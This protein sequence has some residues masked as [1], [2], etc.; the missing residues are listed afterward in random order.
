MVLLS[1]ENVSKSFGIK[2]LFTG[3]TVGL[4]DGEKIGVIGA[5]GS[6]KST[7]LKVIAGEEVPDTGRVV[8]STG[9]LVA[10][11]PQNPPFDPEA[12][13]LA[14]VFHGGNDALQSKLDLIQSYELACHEL[15]IDGGTDEK[16]LGRVS[17]L[18]HELEVTGA[19]Q[20]ESDA[21]AMLTEL[22]VV[23]LTAKM[24]TLSGGQRKR[25]ALAHSLLI[26]PDLLILDEPTNHLDA[27]TVEWL[28]RALMNFRGALLLVTHDRYFLDRV[29]NRM[30]E[31]ERGKVQSFTGNYASY[32]EQ[33]QTQ[34]ERQAVEAQKLKQMARR[35][36]EWLRRGPKARTTKAKARIDRAEGVIQQAKQAATDL[37]SRRS[38]ELTFESSRLGGKI[39]TLHNLTHG[40]GDRI[41]IRNFSYQFKRGDRIGVIGP[42]GVGK[43]TFMEILAGQLKPQS[44]EVEIGQ[45]V[46]ISYYRQENRDFDETQRLI[47]HIREVAERIQL[48]DGET[49]T[50]G[51]M[52]ERFLFPP[53][54][55]YQ[56]IG[57][58]S[59]GERR[60]LSLLRQLMSAPNMLL[61]DEVTNDLDLP[62][63]VALEDYLESFPGCLVI[64]SHDRYFI[65]R[66]VETIFRLEAGGV[67]REYPGNYS[68]FREIMERERKE[69]AATLRP[70]RGAT[71]PAPVALVAPVP[72]AE[73]AVADL[74]SD[75][76]KKL[77]FKEKRELEELEVKIATMEQRKLEVEGQLAAQGSDH[78]A[79]TQLYAELQELV[80]VLERNLTRWTELAERES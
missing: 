54:M 60:R 69:A 78:L 6:G 16:L 20:I 64:V 57:T 66:T 39:V 44:G 19:W 49:I 18:A 38:L 62:T 73:V 76:R 61:L 27:E 63:L 29:T 46:A 17:D 70:A 22:G 80:G 53:A 77:S 34:G 59:G 43:T 28:E 75:G 4:E 41:L 36:L 71:Q 3:V 32:L 25:V 15:E 72:V 58:L 11:L 13:V 40:Y 37:A 2:P 50:A 55:Q 45:T 67:I 30:I 68:N 26:Q 74:R 23:D 51:Q 42:N 1:L 52:L 48:A 9:R 14:A 31:I 24:G 5:N 56:P 12:S 21:K 79:V 33:K 8:I 65:D 47:D 10:T 35:E 7:L